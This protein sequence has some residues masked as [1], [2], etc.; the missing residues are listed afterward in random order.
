MTFPSFV[1]TE[2]RLRLHRRSQGIAEKEKHV[3]IDR[4][5]NYWLLGPLAVCSGKHWMDGAAFYDG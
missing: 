1:V 3:E 2:A 4:A 5:P